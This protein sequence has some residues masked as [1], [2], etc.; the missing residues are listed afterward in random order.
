MKI[1]KNVNY[2]GNNSENNLGDFYIPKSDGSH[3]MV[4]CI[5]GGGWSSMDRSS[6]AGVAEFLCERGFAAF[7]IEYRLLSNAPW[8]ACGDDCLTAARFILSDNDMLPKFKRDKLLIVGASAG[9]HL[10]LM[11]GLRLPK[12]RVHGIVSISGIADIEHDRLQF[13]TRYMKFWPKA[14]TTVDLCGAS[15]LQYIYKNQPPILCTHCPAD[16]VVS[17][18]GTRKFVQRSE[19]IQAVA[20][21]FEYDRSP[22]ADISHCIWVPG[23]SPHKLYP[24]IEESILTFARKVIT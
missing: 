5:H 15:P 19:E 18:T 3:K 11:T 10:A 16:N 21:L 8:P 12:E 2:G 4:L 6:F 17:I 14:P 13:P 23:S 22:D 7:N 9:G 24:E 1:I 20:E